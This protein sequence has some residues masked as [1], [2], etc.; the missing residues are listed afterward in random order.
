MRGGMGGKWVG[1]GWKRG[2]EWDLCRQAAVPS[3]QDG[4]L[5]MVEGPGL[6]GAWEAVHRL[7][8]RRKGPEQVREAAEEDSDA[9]DP[10]QLGYDVGDHGG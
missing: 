5:V 6:V 8:L 4:G 10:P 7:K 1:S 9:A 2:G 3:R